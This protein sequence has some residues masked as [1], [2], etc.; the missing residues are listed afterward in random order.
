MSAM[1][2]KLYFR[3]ILNFDLSL[4]SN[5]YEDR[6]VYYPIQDQFKSLLTVSVVFIDYFTPLQF[7]SSHI[8]NLNNDLVLCQ[9]SLL[10][11]GR[12]IYFC[13]PESM[14]LVIT[15]VCS[16]F[17]FFFLMN[18]DLCYQIQVREKKCTSIRNLLGNN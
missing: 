9:L 8:S 16:F 12:I 15:S 5:F 6:S 13:S 18:T 17:F 14:N 11:V 3:M 2:F 10:N 1:R 4:E 7:F